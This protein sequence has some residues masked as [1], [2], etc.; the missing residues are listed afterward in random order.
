MMTMTSQE[1]P[2][3]PMSLTNSFSEY[4]AY[5]DIK[6]PSKMQLAAGPQIL[7]FELVEFTANKT[8]DKS[9]LK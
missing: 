3:G 2:Q 8:F 1:T 4:K 5:G 9:L 6:M 7:N